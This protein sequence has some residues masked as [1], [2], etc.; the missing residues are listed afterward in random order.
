MFPLVVMSSLTRVR[1]GT[2]GVRRGMQRLG[3]GGVLF[4]LQACRN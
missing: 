1:L 2:G 4:L 3:T